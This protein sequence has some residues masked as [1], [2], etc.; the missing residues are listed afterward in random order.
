MPA[1][2]G[3]VMRTWDNRVRTSSY[4]EDAVL[5]AYGFERI[6]VLVSD[7]YFVDPAPR[8]GQEGAERGVRLEVRMLGRGEPKGSIYSAS[9]IEIGQPIWRVDLLE[10]VS[11]P[12]GSLDRVHHHPAF[13]GWEPGRRQFDPELSANPVAWLGI[14]LIDLPAV[15]ARAGIP[16]DGSFA[17]DAEALYGRTPEIMVAVQGLLDDVKAGK[18]GLAPAGE[19]PESARLSWL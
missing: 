15:L 16:D 6:G 10:T 3:G 4:R 13:N 8:P 7:L 9:P 11:G 1:G 17:A 19:Q 14:Q 2:W 5:Y 12:A 18:A